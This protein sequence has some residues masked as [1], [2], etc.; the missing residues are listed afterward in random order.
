M[1]NGGRATSRPGVNAAIRSR[2]AAT[3]RSQRWPSNWNAD[4][5]EA[6]TSAV[7][8]RRSRIRARCSRVFTVSSLS[9]RHSAVSWV[10]RPS[11]SRSMNTA[12]TESGSA[13]TARS[14]I[15]A[16]SRR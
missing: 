2:T 16:S 5:A 3:R 11:T 15:A 1:A 12:R 7:S 14:M 10:L 8:V 13:A 9:P 4:A 6:P